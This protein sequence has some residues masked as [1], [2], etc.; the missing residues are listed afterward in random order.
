[1]TLKV[2]G[3][4]VKAAPKQKARQEALPSLIIA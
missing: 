3:L 1:M 2:K 4:P